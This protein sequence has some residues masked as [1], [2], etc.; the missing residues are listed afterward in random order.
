MA[1]SRSIKMIETAV[2]V[3]ISV[4]TTAAVEI[5]NARCK[6]FVI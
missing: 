4:N 2:E 6:G 1:D 5:R 3:P